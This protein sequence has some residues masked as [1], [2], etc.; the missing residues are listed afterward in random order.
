MSGSLLSGFSGVLTTKK[1][2]L[3]GLDSVEGIDREIVDNIKSFRQ[4]LGIESA[5]ILVIIAELR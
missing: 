4:I 3:E 2:R 5:Q 1:Y